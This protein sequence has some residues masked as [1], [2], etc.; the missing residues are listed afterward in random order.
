M[1][2]EIWEECGPILAGFFEIYYKTIAIHLAAE[3]KKKKPEGPDDQPKY[4]PINFG[5]T[6][7]SFDMFSTGGAKEPVKKSAAFFDD[8][9]D[10]AKTV[11][12][13][14]Q[15]AAELETGYVGT[16]DNRQRLLKRIEAER[17]RMTGE[18]P[19]DQEPRVMETKT[20]PGAILEEL[21][22]LFPYGGI[23]AKII[24]DQNNMTEHV[25]NA[26]VLCVLEIRWRET[27]TIEQAQN[28]YQTLSKTRGISRFDW[29]YNQH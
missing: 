15:I 29:E 5:I 1:P 14:D 12:Q 27:N 19:E 25:Y 28:V 23:G 16:E 22:P 9:I 4:N 2:P 17:A 26:D 21:A 13:L 6:G 7:P 3:K 24:V 11:E 18:T 10:C 20:S 8:D